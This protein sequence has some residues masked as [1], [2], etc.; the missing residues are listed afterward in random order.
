MSVWAFSI[1]DEQGL[2]FTAYG[3][4]GL[5]FNCVDGLPISGAPLVA[6]HRLWALGLSRRTWARSGGPGSRA[7][8]LQ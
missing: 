6:V 3:E 7:Y 8:R 1:C 2:V 5:F 4:W